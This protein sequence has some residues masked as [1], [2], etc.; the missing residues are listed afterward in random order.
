MPPLSSP[1]SAPPSA[2]TLQPPT[3]AVLGDVYALERDEGVR[4]LLRRGWTMG[5]FYIESPA[6]RSLFDKLRCDTFEMV[7]AA[8]SVIR[9]GVAESGM[10]QEFVARATGRRAVTYPHPEMKRL[11]GGTFGVMVYQEDVLRVAHEIG[12]LTL[13][14]ADCLRR[15]MSGKGRSREAMNRLEAKFFDSCRGRGFSEALAGELW[16][17]IASFAQYAFCKGHSAAFAVLSFQMTWLKAHYPAEFLA[18]VLA[19]RGGF[20]STAAYVSEARRLGI[21]VSGPCVNASRLDWWGRTARRPGEEPWWRRRDRAEHQHRRGGR[22]KK[23]AQAAEA[24]EGAGKERRAEGERAEEAKAPAGPTGWIRAGLLGIAG[25]SPGLIE[26]L[27][28]RRERDGPFASPRDLL[29]RTDP[30]PEEARRLILSGACDTF[31]RPRAALMVEQAIG[32]RMPKSPEATLF[33]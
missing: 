22:A 1:P 18:G 26:R 31:G 24:Q 8:S 17:Q 16:R 7:V 2:P 29:D 23:T 5:C 25:L 21:V 27:L 12:G 3:L 10:M 11:L 28:A 4:T 19:N 32:E 14:E 33:P 20:Y 30:R 6:M 9:P 13:G 15:A